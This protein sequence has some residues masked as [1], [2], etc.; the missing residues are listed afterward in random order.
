M[1][2]LIIIYY[3]KDPI[4]L[5]TFKVPIFYV[6]DIILK[7]VGGPYYFHFSHHI[8]Q[9]FI[10]TYNEFYKLN[11][12]DQNMKLAKLIV[13]WEERAKEYRES[14]KG[15]KDLPPTWLE[16]LNQ[17][18]MFL[19]SVPQPPPPPIQQQ[20]Y[21]QQ[22]FHPPV[23]HQQYHQPITQSN[24]Y[25]I[26]P[27]TSNKRSHGGELIG[28]GIP[29]PRSTTSLYHQ[30]PQARPLQSSYNQ[31]QQ[32]QQQQYPVYQQAQN[33]QQN[34]TIRRPDLESMIMIEMKSLYREMGGNE[35]EMTLEEL[36]S[37][38]PT[39][40]A[41]M[42]A[43][44]EANINSTIRNSPILDGSSFN[45]IQGPKV[46]GY[47]CEAPVT[48]HLSQSEELIKR[49]ESFKIN[50]NI[51]ESI[52]KKLSKQLNFL[53]SKVHEHPPL[54]PMILGHLPLEPSAAFIALCDS[55]KKETVTPKVI[56]FPKFTTNDVISRNDKNLRLIL[57]KF[58]QDRPFVHREDA[59]R[60]SSREKL[61]KH[62]DSYLARKEIERKSANELSYR[63]YYCTLLQWVSDFN[64]LET[65]SNLKTNPAALL[66]K[67]MKLEESIPLPFDENF[68][69]C[70]VSKESFE[71]TFEKNEGEWM[72]KNASKVLVS[73][74]A[75]ANIYKLGQSTSEPS[76]RYLIVHNELVLKDWLN[77]GRATT[78]KDAKE[79]YEA[80]GAGDDI[81]IKSLEKAADG[82]VVYVMLKN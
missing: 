31:L 18:R 80:I 50:S 72:Y 1:I 39:L 78:L 19:S 41:Q 81:F 53:I 59:V 30:Q 35:D 12:L 28:N 29:D 25:P 48:I 10:L 37:M 70:P 3:Y 52:S 77:C 63:Q 5:P 17:M 14:T 26:Q 54:P 62:M 57:K 24:V 45:E 8:A 33:F 43:A 38:N 74:D 4:T 61:A 36:A 46:N 51:P 21:N 11:I 9:I 44:A 76:I 71:R 22:Q 49:L 40:Y 34:N 65:N 64:A 16:A 32:Q 56:E 69:R 23:I 20:L 66:Q 82:E 75:D 79:R 67:S 55:S 47:I 58:N 2:T 42:R 15:T 13:T 7:K 6:I 27:T 73:E 68:M 60:F